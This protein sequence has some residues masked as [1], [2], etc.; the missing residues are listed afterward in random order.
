MNIIRG[1]KYHLLRLIIQGKVEGKT[2]TGRKKLSWLRNM[3]QQCRTTVEELFRAAAD[4]EGFQE[5]I[6]FNYVFTGIKHRLSVQRQENVIILKSN[7]GSDRDVYQY[8]CCSK[9]TLRRS[10]K[11][12]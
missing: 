9:Y 5:L 10:F 3:R 4:R 2:W 6:I 8:L 11:K 7:V 12:Q 1:N